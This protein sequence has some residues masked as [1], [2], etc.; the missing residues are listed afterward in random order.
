MIWNENSKHGSD[1]PFRTVSTRRWAYAGHGCSQS[2]ASAYLSAPYLAA[3]VGYSFYNSPFLFFSL[4]CKMET[5]VSIPLTARF[6]FFLMFP[7]K[8]VW[9]ESISEMCVDGSFWR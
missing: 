1:P 8:T 5:E 9:N 2:L 6:P 4:F 7:L 3:A